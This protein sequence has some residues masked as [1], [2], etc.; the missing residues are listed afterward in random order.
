MQRLD[1]MAQQCPVAL[2]DD[3]ARRSGSR[4]TAR[5]DLREIVF[6][7]ANDSRKAIAGVAVS[8]GA[9]LTRKRGCRP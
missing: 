8:A 9:V 1:R 2:R 7:K 4:R 5:P 3:R 6:K